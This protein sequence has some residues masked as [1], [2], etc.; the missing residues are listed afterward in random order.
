MTSLRYAR[1]FSLCALH[2]SAVPL[3]PPR[4]ALLEPRR[5]VDQQRAYGELGRRWLPETRHVLQPLV[6]RWD[7]DFRAW[8]SDKPGN[9]S[10]AL[11][12]STKLHERLAYVASLGEPAASKPSMSTL[13]NYTP[14]RFEE[15]FPEWA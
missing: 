9:L 7:A 6:P 14:A 3:R 12:R 15:R 1:A 8:H 10:A 2:P 5:C 4:E 13:L 11:N